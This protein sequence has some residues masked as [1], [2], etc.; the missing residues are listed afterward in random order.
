MKFDN[1]LYFILKSRVDNTHFEIQ[2]DENQNAL[3]EERMVKSYEIDDDLIKIEKFYGKYN[4]GRVHQP[5]V[6]V[7]NAQIFMEGR[8]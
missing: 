2:F 1:T 4:W 5:Q 8:D 7:L 3:I 6:E